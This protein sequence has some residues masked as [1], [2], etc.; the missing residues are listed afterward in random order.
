MAK[1]A[2]KATNFDV[3]MAKFAPRAAIV[4]RV[5]PSPPATDYVEYR[6]PDSRFSFSRRCSEAT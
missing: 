5:P 1:A 4:A 6:D 3:A 2:A